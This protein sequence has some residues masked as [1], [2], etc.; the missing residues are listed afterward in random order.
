MPDF[1][2]LSY[3]TRRADQPGL[4]VLCRLSVSFP[5][6][7][8]RQHLDKDS[9][10]HRARLKAARLFR[11]LRVVPVRQ[12]N[13]RGRFL[14]E[15]VRRSKYIGKHRTRT[16]QASCPGEPI[17]FGVVGPVIERKTV[18]IRV[19]FVKRKLAISNRFWEKVQTKQLIPDQVVF[20]A[21]GTPLIERKPEMITFKAHLLPALD[22]IAG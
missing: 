12:W 15:S 6:F 9:S 8:I 13:A 1:S 21:P 7:R 18:T 20:L 3:D 14:S 11:R 16:G 17:D 5:D 22:I 4:L 2:S 10:H 19:R